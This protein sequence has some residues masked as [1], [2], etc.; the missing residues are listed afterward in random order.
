M[1]IWQTLEELGPGGAQGARIWLAP[2][3]L[4]S[5]R[6]WRVGGW[7]GRVT[8]PTWS[9]GLAQ[10]EGWGSQQGGVS[11]GPTFSWDLAG[12]KGQG[13]QQ[14]MDPAVPHGTGTWQNPRGMVP[15]GV[16]IWRSHT[17]LRP[18]RAWGVESPKRWSS[19]S[20]DLCGEYLVGQ[21]F[22]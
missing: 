15:I 7:H 16:C 9:L 14:G 3:Q 19:S 8:G 4:A 20:A 18:D 21:L 2:A 10:P 11:G 12:P 5:G 6:A 17:E 22:F 1:R 13:D